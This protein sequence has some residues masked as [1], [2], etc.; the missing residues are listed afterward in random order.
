MEI[1][2]RA[3]KHGGIKVYKPNTWAELKEHYNWHP[4]FEFGDIPVEEIEWDTGEWD[5]SFI[6]KY[7][8]GKQ[9]Q[10]DLIILTE[11]IE[12]KNAPK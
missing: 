10:S 3:G 5:H 8:N 4:D 2:K 11:L 12:F 6:K 9:R 1:Y 7:L